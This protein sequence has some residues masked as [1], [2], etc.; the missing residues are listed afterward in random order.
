M[1]N[2]VASFRRYVSEFAQTMRTLR[3]LP[4]YSLTVAAVSGLSMCLAVATFRLVDGVLFKPLPYERPEELAQVS[5]G[6]SPE[7]VAAA[8]QTLIQSAGLAISARDVGDLREAIPT[9]RFTMVGGSTAG[10]TLGDLRAW[11]PS[12]VRVD[13]HFFEVLGIRPLMGGFGADD[14]SSAEQAVQPAL[15]SYRVWQTRLGGRTDALGQILSS[16]TATGVPLRYRVAGILRKDFIYPTGLQQP[17]ILTPLILSEAQRTQ[18]TQRSFQAYVRLPPDIPLAEYQTRFDLVGRAGR[19]EIPDRTLNGGLGYWDRWAIRPLSTTMGTSQRPTFWSVFAAAGLLV[20]LGCLNVSGLVAARTTDRMREFTLRRALGGGGRDIGRLVTFECLA[21]IGTGSLVGIVASGWLVAAVVHVL[22]PNLGLL[23][24]PNIDWRVVVFAIAMI[25]ASTLLV[26]LWPIRRSLRPQPSAA[27]SVNTTPVRSVGRALAI[28]GQVALAF[29]LT[30]GGSFLIGS[31]IRIWHTDIGYS[32]ANLLVVDGVV[33]SSSTEAR[34]L[35]LRDFVERSRRLP[36]VAA[37]GATQSSLLRGGS[38]GGEFKADTYR[39]SSGFLEA[40]GPQLLEGRFPT[41]EELET[42]QPVAVVSR[43]FAKSHVSDGRAIGRA[44]TTPNGRE[45]FT[46]VGVVEDA[47]YAAW[48]ADGRGRQFYRPLSDPSRFSLA[49]R[50]EPGAAE[51]LTNLLITGRDVPDIRLTRAALAEELL[52]ETIRPQRF[53]S[54]LFGTFSVAA[55]VIMGIGILGLVASVVSR[56]GR[57]VGIRMAL[58]SSSAGILLLMVR[59]QLTPVAVGLVSGIAI[60]L[61][62]VGFVKGYLYG[63]T[64]SDPLVWGAAVAVICIVAIIGVLIPAT[65]WSRVNP[66]QA[67]RAE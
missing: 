4:W 21:L 55:L 24:S 29:V 35:A 36:G 9:A 13:A 58:G 39:V 67:L 34:M 10:A 11:S 28:A 46:I 42:N 27:F 33:G 53:R 1:R 7:V 5:G 60:S 52:A 57:E 44:I 56:R 8:G 59:E 20:L 41:P 15:I 40:M 18:R 26:A 64:T 66:V 14:F 3:R 25:S 16:E 32:P 54:W 47:R 63:L 17:D 43:T 38:P 45:T 62:A 65:R 61:W 2:P 48:V 6:Y 23:R 37:I 31:L 50:L 19:A 22:P 30:I 49:V 51:V 12:V